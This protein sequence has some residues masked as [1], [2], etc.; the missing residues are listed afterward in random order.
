MFLK[1][2]I[3]IKSFV[4]IAACNINCYE[5]GSEKNNTTYV[6]SEITS[7]A[8]H[9]SIALEGRLQTL[10]SGFEKYGSDIA[11][12]QAEHPGGVGICALARRGHPVG[13]LPK[14]V[15]DRDGSSGRINSN[16]IF[17]TP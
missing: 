7:A 16:C 5:I 11:S 3:I 17:E 9:W 12:A 13:S 4:Q 6:I 15:L 8:V 10:R 1:R 2:V 14:M